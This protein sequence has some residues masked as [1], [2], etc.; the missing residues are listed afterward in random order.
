[1]VGPVIWFSLKTRFPSDCE[2]HDGENDQ[3]AFRFTQEALDDPDAWLQLRGVGFRV[4]VPQSFR[5][6][7]GSQG[8]GLGTAPQVDRA[9]QAPK[10]KLGCA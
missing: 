3:A 2:A 5:I 6:I 8:W 4:R 9:Q 7:L 10:P 1:M